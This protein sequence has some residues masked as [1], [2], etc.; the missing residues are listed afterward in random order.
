METRDSQ[1]GLFFFSA[2]ILKTSNYLL[3]TADTYN[4][5]TF[6]FLKNSVITCN[7]CTP[8][9]K[10]ADQIRFIVFDP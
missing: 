8:G 9:G 5:F 7:L 4:K 1:Y 10:K 3:L 6:L 2:N